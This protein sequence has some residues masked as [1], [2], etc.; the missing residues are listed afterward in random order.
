MKYDNESILPNSYG[1]DSND[2]IHL[3]DVHKKFGLKKL[4]ITQFL[5]FTRGFFIIL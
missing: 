4:K 5:H 2:S 1:Y 3:I